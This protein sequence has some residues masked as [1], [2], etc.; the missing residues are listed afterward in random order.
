MLKTPYTIILGSQSPRRKQLLEGLDIEFKVRTI[1]I[2]ET[3]PNDIPLNTVAEY[4]AREK[5]KAHLSSMN[6]NELIITSDTVVVCDNQILGKPKN[7]VHAQEMLRMLSG[8]TH[9]VITGVCLTSKDKT[10]SFSDV[11]KVV[12][13]NLTTEQIDY[14]IDIYQPFDKAGGYGIQEWIGYTG[15]SSIEGSYFNVMGLPV[16]RIYDVLIADFTE[17]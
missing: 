10:I 7:R 8:K 15:I 17:N 2:D 9:E 12:F 16:A 3:F 5:G 13:K 6:E 11:T 1:E 14:Y 4:L